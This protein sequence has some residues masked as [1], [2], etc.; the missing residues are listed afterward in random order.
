M[1]R[2]FVVRP[3]RPP[4]AW[5]P[6][7]PTEATGFD[8]AY[9]GRVLAA[10]ERSLEDD[11]LTFYLAW[12][13]GAVGELPSYGP[14]VVVIGAVGEAFPGLPWW[15]NRVRV[16]F[17]AGGLRPELGAW[18]P[19]PPLVPALTALGLCARGWLRELPGG[20]AAL[21]GRIRRGGRGP[22]PRHLVPLGYHG[23]IELPVKPIA[24]RPIALSFAG[25]VRHW[26]G[27]W[28]TFTA[29]M[30]ASKAR[31]RREMLNALCRLQRAHPDV[32]TKVRITSSF[33]DWSPASGSYDPEADRAYCELLMNTK[34]CLVPRGTFLETLRHFEALR[35]GCIVV[36]DAWPDRW[37][38]RDAPFI[39][40]RSWD[41]LQDAVLPLLSDE[42]ELER[43]H[44]S[45][46]EYWRTRCSEEAVGQFMADRL[47]EFGSSPVSD[48]ALDQAGLVAR[49]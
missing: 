32:P 46:L 13:L 4:V 9:W 42:G 28:G 1:N 30:G 44:R 31:A 34:I 12:S 20:A 38:L 22:C 41:R 39:L 49:T 2:Y 29:A 14:R 24:E 25:S 15:S 7:E 23:Q 6:P 18:A 17:K 48:H 37:Y 3:G 43:L 8:M 40:V 19:S 47:N 11:D 5:S 27:W 36:T 33:L 35:A 21:A 10:M 45:S 26:E 16:V